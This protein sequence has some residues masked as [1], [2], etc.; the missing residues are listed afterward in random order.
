MFFIGDMLVILLTIVNVFTKKYRNRLNHSLRLA[1]R[2]YYGK[3]LKKSKSSLKQTWKFLNGAINRK[4]KINYL[5]Y[6]QCLK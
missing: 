6:L 1:K 4:R 3:A 2:L 5:N